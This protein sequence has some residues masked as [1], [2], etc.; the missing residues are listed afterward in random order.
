MS[1]L[2]LALFSQWS[3]N[4]FP[5]AP[6]NAHERES[7]VER[8]E[9]KPASGPDVGQGAPIASFSQSVCANAVSMT[10]LN[11]APQVRC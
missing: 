1:A 2:R 6:S 5:F 3:G 11:L 4:S 10:N 7:D 8:S 9:T